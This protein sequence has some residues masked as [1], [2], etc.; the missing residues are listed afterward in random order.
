M[1]ET[2]IKSVWQ[3]LPPFCCYNDSAF[4]YRLL[5]LFFLAYAAKHLGKLPHLTYCKQKRRVSV[6]SVLRPLFTRIFLLHVAI[7]L[8]NFSLGPQQYLSRGSCTVLFQGNF[9][10]V[11]IFLL[12]CFKL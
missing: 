7:T 4:V 5:L 6:P 2:G 12:S 11:Q 10:L 3:S 8:Q 9:R 1:S